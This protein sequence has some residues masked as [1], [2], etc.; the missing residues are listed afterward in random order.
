MWIN[1]RFDN[2]ALFKIPNLQTF[3]KAGANS[4]I[5]GKFD[6]SPNI[7]SVKSISSNILSRNPI[8]EL[9]TIVS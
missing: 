2:F 7:G 4:K 8:K 5:I 9:N 6:D 3:V 1:E